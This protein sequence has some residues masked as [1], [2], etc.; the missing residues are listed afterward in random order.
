MLDA[1]PSMSNSNRFCLPGNTN[2]TTSQKLWIRKSLCNL[3]GVL[4]S[5][6]KVLV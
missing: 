1:G 2:I 3:T 6:E 5:K 4:V